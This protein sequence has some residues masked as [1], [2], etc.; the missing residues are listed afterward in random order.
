MMSISA[1]RYEVTSRPTSC[2]RTAGFVQTFIASSYS[3]SCLPTMDDPAEGPP[4]GADTDPF[5]CRSSLRIRTSH[6]SPDRRGRYRPHERFERQVKTS[7][8][9]RVCAVIDASASARA[10][11]VF[12]GCDLHRAISRNAEPSS[13]NDRVLRRRN[14]VRRSAVRTNERAPRPGRAGPVGLACVNEPV[15]RQALPLR[16][17]SPALLETGSIIW[18][19]AET[20]FLFMPTK[21]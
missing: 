7:S 19:I 17:R 9:T 18:L 3:A 1:G 20:M 6:F 14:T 4:T 2:S 15:W 12:T 21:P 10:A 5:E 13:R 8:Q 16:R 11:H